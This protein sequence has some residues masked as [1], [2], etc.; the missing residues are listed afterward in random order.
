MA[1]RLICVC[2]RGMVLP[3]KYAGQHVQCPD[4]RAMLRV[5]TG[6]E[7]LG[8]MRWFCSCG[9]RLKARSRAA[10]QK[11]RCP[12][13]AA[14]VA[15]PLLDEHESFVEEQFVVEAEPETAAPVQVEPVE[16]PSLEEA[17]VHEAAEEVEP[18]VEE[19]AEGEDELELLPLSG[20]ET[21]EP[22]SPAVELA[23]LAE[24]TG[25]DTYD[26]S[27]QKPEPPQAP[28]AAVPVAPVVERGEAPLAED[29]EEGIRAREISRYFNVRSGSEAARTAVMQVLN[30]YWLYIPYALL[31]VCMNYVFVL[32][33][34]RAQGSVGAAIA[35]LFLPIVFSL[36]LW[37]AFIGCIK[38]GIFERLMGIERMLY[39]GAKHI[40]RFTG[41]CILMVPVGIGL[42]LA[43]VAGAAAVA[44]L[45]PDLTLKIAIIIGAVLVGM[46]SLVWLMI[47]PVVS[48]VEQTNPIFALGRGLLFGITHLWD[49]ITLTVMSMLIAAV[50]AL[51]V[52][53]I[54][55][56][57]SLL[58]LMVLPLWLFA[59][60][61]NLVG[62][63]VGAA[64]MGQII[65]AIM[66]LYLSNL[67][68]EDLQRIRAKL[69]GPRTT[70]WRH[71][72]SIG[73]LA[74]AMIVLSYFGGRK[75]G[76]FRPGTPPAMEEP[77]LDQ[78]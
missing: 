9:L 51:V 36:F 15:V 34:S 55:W 67:K 58:L 46:F 50:T 33:R 13:C 26:I 65:S 49:L 41:T 30:G 72:A 59:A 27:R 4:C 39:H 32:V 68:E 45:A 5:P 18:P 29:E 56:M 70:D 53:L 20:E 16:E 22:H 54:W 25:S 14:E 37:S 71:Y 12:R 69:R 43:G 10:G 73:V 62:S 74:V 21:E 23:V 11:I 48:I 31:G 2:G 76:Y 44:E 64:I 1:I 77:P 57:S 42:W 78:P 3:D 6:D 35:L 52:Y 75:L 63:F 8:L 28:R 40:L 24:E 17:P 38:D 7:D 66:L 47:P 60:L 19:A 61:A